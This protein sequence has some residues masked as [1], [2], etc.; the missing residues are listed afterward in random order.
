MPI[1]H[2]IALGVTQGL[3]EF[4]P[5]SSSG[6]LI[7]VPWLFGWHDF[8]RQ[9]H[10]EKTFD[11]ALHAG[12]FV[13][14]VAYF[15]QDIAAFARAGWRSMRTRSITGD[16][17]RMAWLLLLSALPGALIGAAF[18]TT[19][20]DKLGKIWLIATMLIVFG[21]VL[22]VA[23][24]LSGYREANDFR[25]RDAVI[26]GALQ[27]AALQ[28]GVSRS[29]VTITAGRALRFNRDGATRISFLMSLPIIGGAALYKGLKVMKEGGIPAG[30]GPAFAWGTAAS[31]LTGFIAVW[32][33]LRLVRRQTF[34]PFVV[35]RV[36][37][38]IAVLS[39][40]ASSFR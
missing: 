29:G 35:Y 28:P 10:L 21:L 40:L 7:L 30:F 5:I 3:S 18:E 26:M 24:R 4:L 31:A 12:T 15:R 14:A 34:T 20:E 33:L 36:L 1:V 27:A 11:V 39:I 8:L 16:A 38:G 9:P 32:F 25:L 19:I 23:D 6:H 22:L 2:A 17:D 37:A 13:G